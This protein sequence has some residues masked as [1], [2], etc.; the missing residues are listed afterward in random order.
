MLVDLVDVC[1]AKSIPLVSVDG[2]FTL[3]PQSSSS[4]CTSPKCYRQSCAIVAA[5]LC[6]NVVGVVVA[7]LQKHLADSAQ[8]VVQNRREELEHSLRESGYLE[9]ES[10]GACEVSERIDVSLLKG[11]SSKAGAVKALDVST[12]NEAM[13]AYAE[14]IGKGFPQGFPGRAD[15][16]R[17]RDG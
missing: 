3:L 13:E 8:D 4:T 12:T 10:T 11:E 7:F 9:D 16:M 17:A 14:E 1:F 15:R 6:E 2:S 5:Y